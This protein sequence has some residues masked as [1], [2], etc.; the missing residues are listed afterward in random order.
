MGRRSR[1]HLTFQSQ[2]TQWGGGGVRV[3][4]THL[5]LR[6]LSRETDLPNERTVE[7]DGLDRKVTEVGNTGILESGPR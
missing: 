5:S 2:L 4:V 1:S 7:G 6:G 3:G